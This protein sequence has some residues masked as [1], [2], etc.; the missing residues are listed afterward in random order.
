MLRP[1]CVVACAKNTTLEIVWVCGRYQ[2]GKPLGSGTFG[3]F[4]L[5]S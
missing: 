2:V 5:R 4:I 1:S 3:T